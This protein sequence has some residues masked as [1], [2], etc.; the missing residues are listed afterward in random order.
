MRTDQTA[1]GTTGN[2][3]PAAGAEEGEAGAAGGPMGT[4]SS[5]PRM[6]HLLEASQIFPL[7]CDNNGQLQT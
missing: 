2:K 5:Q 4:R 7:P 1:A 6:L 3:A